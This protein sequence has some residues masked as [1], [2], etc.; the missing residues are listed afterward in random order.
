MSAKTSR[1]PLDEQQKEWD[2][3]RDESY[4]RHLKMAA[5]AALLYLPPCAW[6]L[7]G[8]VGTPLTALVTVAQLCSLPALALLHAKMSRGPRP[9]QQSFDENEQIYEARERL[10]SRRAQGDAGTVDAP[11]D[12]PF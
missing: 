2:R 6:W 5:L 8:I 12:D 11:S 4:R 1:P 3:H 10:A 9:T 7:H